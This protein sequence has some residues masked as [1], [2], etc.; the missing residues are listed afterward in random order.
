MGPE[1]MTRSRKILIAVED[2]LRASL[3]EQLAF[4]PEFALLEADAP[5]RALELIDAQP[6]DVLLLDAGLRDDET[7]RMIETARSRGFGGAIVLLSADEGDAPAGVDECVPRP[8]RFAELL[9][10]L[11]ARLF[12][13]A[14]QQYTSVAVGPYAFDIDSHDLVD[15]RGKRVRLTEKEAAILAR[16]ARAK[17]AVTLKEVLLREVW[18]FSPAVTTRTLETHIHRLRRKIEPDPVRPRL[19]LTAPGG[20]RLAVCE[21]PAPARD[22]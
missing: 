11:R 6:P 13:G 17:G 1:Q 7:R 9:A 22:Q 16:L 8:F 5:E 10:R 4:F 21:A 15:R 18:G 20:Y 19:L 3:V 14:A 2:G 12:A